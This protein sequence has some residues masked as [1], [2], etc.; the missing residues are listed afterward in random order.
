MPAF[1]RSVKETTQGYGSASNNG[2]VITTVQAGAGTATVTIPAT[3]ATTPAGGTAFNSNGGPAP[4]RGIGRI[5]T[6]ALGGA[7]T[8]SFLV[9]VTD[10]V[11]TLVVF[12]TPVSAAS[13]LFDIQFEFVTDLNINSVTLTTVFAVSGGTVDF[14]LSMMP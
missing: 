13:Q 14:E 8:T 5:R 10:G 9:T 2:S 1:V 12:S 4:T 6:S 11:T 7:S 3:G